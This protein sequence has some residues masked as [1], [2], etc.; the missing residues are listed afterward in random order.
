MNN[1][2][3]CNANYDDDYQRAAEW[4]EQLSE[5]EQRPLDELSKR[6]LLAW[7]DAKPDRRALFERMLSTWSDPALTRAAQTL[8]ANSNP[9]RPAAF[10]AN[11]WRTSLAFSLC[12]CVALIASLQLLG[13]DPVAPVTLATSQGIRH[14]LQLEDGSHLEI[15]PASK[16]SVSLTGERRQIALQQGA[17]Y[18]RVAKDKKRPFKVTINEASVVAVGTEFNIDKTADHIEVTV[19]EGAV[20][21]RDRAASRPELLRAGERALINT[22][23]IQRLSVNLQQLVDWRSGWLE[24]ENGKLGQILEQL[25]RYSETPIR[26]QDP[27][28]AQ[29]PVA[30]RFHLKDTETTLQLLT[31]LYGLRLTQ[32]S[33]PE[34]QNELQLTAKP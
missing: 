31:E 10:G 25:N 14:D 30:G 24:L 21:V 6:R 3:S 7:L 15:A 28:L 5:Q 32:G 2:S 16:L 26:L 23:G 1:R 9:S 34:G 12:L 19:Y 22:T 33:S 20:E 11:T 27:A 29:T 17:A 13:T 4:L 18:F 8:L